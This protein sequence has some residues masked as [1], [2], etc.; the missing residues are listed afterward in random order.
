MS[1]R[2]RIELG[3]VLMVAGQGSA[4]PAGWPVQRGRAA[5]QDDLSVHGGRVNPLRVACAASNEGL[6]HQR[7]TYEPGLA[8]RGPADVYRE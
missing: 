5:A 3:P 8:E 2:H 1:V 6:G 4:E 7:A